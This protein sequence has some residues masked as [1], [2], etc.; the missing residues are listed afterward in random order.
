MTGAHTLLRTAPALCHPDHRGESGSCGDSTL[1]VVYALHRISTR[2]KKP[3]LQLRLHIG[4]QLLPILRH[5][6]HINRSV[7]FGVD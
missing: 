2:R 5:I 3:L 4:R 6:K 7:A 1:H